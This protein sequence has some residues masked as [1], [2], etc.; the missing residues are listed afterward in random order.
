L[1]LSRGCSL[2]SDN[3]SIKRT[4]ATGDEVRE[5]F[6][7]FFE[8]KGHKVISSSPLIPYGD[9][10][11]LLT[12]AG[13]VQFKPYFLGEATPPNPRLASCQKCFRTTDIDSVGGAKH[14]TFFEM[15]GN[16]SVGDY[17]KAEAIEW[18]WEFL[19]C[20]ICLPPQR[21]WVTIFPED[22]ESHKRWQE[23]G[24]PA[25]RIKPSQENFWGPAGD[26]GP[27][28]PC[29]E[30]HYDFGEEFGCGKYD[31]GPD[32]NCP[33]FLEIWNLVFTQYNQDKEGKRIRL[34]R[35]NIDTGMGLER[36]V[37][38]MQGKLSVFDTDLFTPII[39]QVSQLAGLTYGQDEV[40][41]RAIRII[42]EHS[43]GITFLIADRVIPSNE[44]RG[45]IL[46]RVLRRA[47]LFGRRL[48]LEQPFLVQVA[49]SVIATMGHVYPE[50]IASRDFILKVINLEEER[51]GQTLNAGLNWL[52][53]MMEQAKVKGG[54]ISGEE[55]FLLYDTYGFPKELAIEVASEEGLAV[56]L[57]GFEQQ[58]EQQ[59]ERARAAQRFGSKERWTTHT[60]AS[61]A[62]LPTDFVG[63]EQTSCQGK[64]VALVVEGYLQE[65]A[66]A[67]QQVEVL[68]DR[69]PFYAEKGG[70]VADRGKIRGKH[71]VI[72]VAEAVWASPSFIVHQGEVSE[73]KIHFG[74][75]VTAQVDNEQRLDIARNHTA[76]HLLQAA[77]RKVLGEHVYQA[78]SLVTPERLRFDFTHLGPIPKSQLIHIQHL[79]NE[80]VRQNLAVTTTTTTT[81][82]EAVAK[83]A[84]AIFGEK[85]GE[86]V[87]VVEIGDPP[88]SIELC[89][90]THLSSTGE[91]GLFHIISEG[92]IGAGERRIE[93]TTG[94]GAEALLEQ[95]L[96]V[97]DRVAQKLEASPQEVP[98]RVEA[99][100][101]ELDKEHKQVLVLERKLASKEAESLLS[102]ARVIDGVNILSART[103][104]TSVETMRE[105]GDQLKERLGSGVIVLGSILS[106]KPHF[107]AMVTPDL[108]ARGFHA[109]EIARQVAKATGGGGGGRP[110]LG[111]GS[112][113][114][115][116]KLDEVL[117]QVYHLC[118]TFSRNAKSTKS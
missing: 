87:R 71:G 106:D 5:L 41:D 25:E 43:R 65:E 7:R 53:R 52:G 63:Y 33:R 91:I 2:S 73:G 1:E 100:V 46:R 76:T 28:G 38:V 104:A 13:M 114:D 112:G 95:H 36:T 88:F 20:R 111:Q 102:E 89:G 48:E 45:Y 3:S 14:L 9:P 107:V 60:F 50:L 72:V 64:I 55:V 77:L 90:G 110:E 66:L 24:L 97:L 27:C 86:V 105:I 39:G 67:G 68:L 17:F 62:V 82:T 117:A 70:Q 18:A 49:E 34:P 108:V 78:G 21:L 116:A 31:C 22:D 57:E 51:F 19:T 40:A 54:K 99:L 109:A 75:E 10:S 81:Y 35:P 32:C 85:Y 59:R 30:I 42:A 15:L 103:L 11:L 56:D 93:A 84:L 37:A 23:M 79:V 16:F 58:M 92:S 26:W 69:T 74:E 94:R 80:K 47:L 83:G 44:G 115:K 29:S 6:L 118:P 4:Q 12:T 96:A 98:G 113:R 61:L 101:V 8:G